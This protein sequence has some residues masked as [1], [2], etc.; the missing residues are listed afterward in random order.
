MD[1]KELLQKRL[2][3]FE[4][5][6]ND[7]VARS[8]ASNSADEVR[9]INEQLVEINEDIQDI[10]DELSVLENE[11]KEESKQEQRDFNPLASYKLDAGKGDERSNDVLSSMEYRKAFMNH[12]QNRNSSTT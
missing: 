9:S 5:K 11:K 1:R 3:K 10:K 2:G 4:K 12:V 6:K 8:N 7:L